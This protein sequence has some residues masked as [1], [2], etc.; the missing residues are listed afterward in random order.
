[1]K[2]RALASC[3]AV[4]ALLALSGTARADK[5]HDTLR[6]AVD[7]P[8]R[9]LDGYLTPNPEADL[10]DRAIY[11]TLVG[12][13][14][15]TRTY[16]GQLAESWTQVDGKTMEFKLRHGVKFHDG[17][18]M[19]A[20]DVIYSFQYGMDPKVNFLFKDSRF[21]WIDHVDKVDD[22]T[23]RVTSKQPTAIMLAR[24]WSA[25]EILPKHIH[26][27]LAD[28]ASFGLHPVGT[29][30]YKVQSYEPASGNIVLVKNPD[31]NWGGY[32]PAAKIGRVEISTIPDAQTRMAKMMVGDLDLI[33]DVD[34]T[35]AKD[36]TAGNPNDK[37]VVAPTISFSYILFDTA[38]RSGIHVFKD[39]RVREAALHAI[40]VKRIRAALLPPEY[41]AKPPMQA[42]C[43]PDHVGCTFSAMPPSYDPAKAKELLKDAGLEGGFDVQ[44]WSWGP[45]NDVAQAV[46]GDLRKVGIRASV[47]A[48]TIN[49]LQTARGE[50]K[51][52][53]L[54]TQWDNGGGAPDVDTTAQFFYSPSSRN[55]VGDAELAQLTADAGRE[56]DAQ[57]RDA[58]YKTLFDKVTNEAYAMP[59]LEFPAVLVLDKNI[60]VDSNHMK[61]EGFLINRL[62]W[63]N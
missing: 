5:A 27:K 32:E 3:L 57:K 30:P 56:L 43:H 63:G 61:P 16:H 45:A 28:K 34:Y 17:T 36:M 42:M 39:K 8:I 50:G 26:E 49:V 35:Q 21:G 55:Y 13:D 7:Q 62:S 44:I 60:V 18:P 38:D 52:Q 54:M 24:L 46:A 29:G 12:Y 19:T 48:T 58:V 22:Y 40:D 53:I 11:D 33:F 4:A 10:V 20:D 6:F 59:V 51:T 25:P 1:M 2:N 15:A 37:I 9:L 41:A 47:N 23:I 31:Y 14:V